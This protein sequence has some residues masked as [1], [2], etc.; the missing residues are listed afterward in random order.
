MEIVPLEDTL[1]VEARIK[2]S[3]IGFLHVGQSTMVKI[4]AYDFSIY[5]RLK[6][7]VEHISADTITDE[8]DHTFYEIWV[9]TSRAFLGTS[10]KSL[11]IIPGTREMRDPEEGEDKN[12]FL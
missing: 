7:K 6:G 3:D 4:T 2:P 5:G 1:R 8:H 9:R 10:K 12:N 11:P